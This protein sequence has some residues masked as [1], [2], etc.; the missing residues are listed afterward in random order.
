MTFEIIYNKYHKEIFVNIVKRI[1]KG[2]IELAEELTNDV[3]LRVN[4]HLTNFDSEKSSLRTWLYNIA[5]NIIID[6]WRKNSLETLSIH[7]EDNEGNEV[8]QFESASPTPHAEI[9]NSE[10]GN[11]IMNAIGSLSDTYKDLAER[12]FIQEQTY[13]EIVKDTGMSIGTVKG[14]INRLRTILQGMLS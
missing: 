11:K 14:K 9:V 3:F 13:N 2:N 5:N 1:G 12:F 4:K 10:L 8:F 7:K 6:H